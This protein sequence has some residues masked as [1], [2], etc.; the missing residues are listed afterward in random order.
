MKKISIVFLACIIFSGSSFADA[1]NSGGTIAELNEQIAI[2]AVR[3]RLLE[4]DLQ[5]AQKRAELAKLNGTADVGKS[6]L[7]SLRAIESVN[8]SMYA[9]LSYAN[10]GTVTVEKG[11]PLSDGWVVAEIQPRGVTLARGKEREQLT[12]RSSS[13]RGGKP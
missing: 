1:N 5:M 11:E 3:I 6:G 13:S 12:L 7:P 9:T 2:M 10:G 8:G 4:A